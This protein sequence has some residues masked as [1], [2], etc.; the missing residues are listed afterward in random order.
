MWG[1]IQTK[2]HEKEGNGGGAQRKAG[3]KKNEHCP[4]Q[5]DG[6]R[7]S[8]ICWQLYGAGLINSDYSGRGVD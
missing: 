3:E 2:W 4:F 1:R 8:G 6:K 5:M 7:F